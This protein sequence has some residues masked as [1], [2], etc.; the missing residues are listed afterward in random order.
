MDL[1]MSIERK[2]LAYIKEDSYAISYAAAQIKR[3]GI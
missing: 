1:S 3:R 2:L